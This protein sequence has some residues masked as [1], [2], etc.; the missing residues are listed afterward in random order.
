MAS[1][2]VAIPALAAD[3]EASAV[4]VSWIPTA[5]LLGNILFMLP[6]GKCADSFG[7]KRIF[8]LGLII[9]TCASIL[10]FFA[11]S[12]EMVLALRFLQ[13]VGSAMLFATGMALLISVFPARQRGLPIGLNAASVY[14]GLTLAPALGGWVT[15]AWGWRYVFLLP[16]P[17][18][19]LVILMLVYRIRGDWYGD[20]NKRFDWRGALLFAAWALT[21]VFAIT[22]LPKPLPF[23]FLA[24]SM[25][26]LVLFV[27]LQ[28]RSAEP[29]IR[30]QMFRENS[31]F[32]MSLLIAALMYAS[33]YPLGFL[34]SLYLQY[35]RGLGAADAGHLLLVQALTMAMVAPFAGRLSDIFSPRWI[36]ACG[37]LC[38]FAGF[39]FL[40]RLDA[41]TSRLVITLGLVLVG[42]GFGFFS[43]P[44]NNMVMNAAAPGEVGVA[45]ATLSLARV[46]GNLVGMSL[47]NL[48]VHWHLG[49]QTMSPALSEPLLSTISNAIMLGLGFLFV[50]TVLSLL[51]VRTRRAVR[52]L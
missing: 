6:A 43:S 7:R 34:L 9:N 28:A 39:I 33:T 23:F 16:L 26:L 15:E 41:D 3:L 52:S 27:R 47:V 18:V 11:G 51:R 45:G 12:I 49:Y 31:V 48:F 44:N 13:G 36:A 37:C 8:L 40:S 20:T 14:L 29:L 50:A 22:G 32:S 5:V 25:V 35:V 24:V 21:F 10:A 42:L 19:T 30:V 4:W 17:I 46:I 1:V 38:V 2:N